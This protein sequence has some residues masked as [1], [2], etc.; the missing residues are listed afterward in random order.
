M[1]KFGR[2]MLVLVLAMG[3]CLGGIVWPTHGVSTVGQPV[4]VNPDLVGTFTDGEGRQIDELRI[5]GRPPVGW[6]APAV[7]LPSD[8]TE[9]DGTTRILTGVPAFDWSYGCSATSA[10]MLFGYYDRLGYPDMYVGPT[11]GGVCPLSNS[12]WGSGETPISASHKDIDGRA[13]KGSVDDYWVKYGST[14][15]DPY[16]TGSWTQHAPLDCTAD[17]MGTNQ[18]KYGN[19]DGSTS[20]YF[21]DDG[22]PLVD[23]MAPAGTMD[24]C[25]GMRMYAQYR[26]YNTATNFSQYIAEGPMGEADGFSFALFTYEIDAGRPVLI[27]CVGHT[28]LAFGYSTTDKTIYIHDTWDHLDHSMTW[29][30]SYSGLQQYGVTVIRLT[31]SAITHTITTSVS[32]GHGTLVPSGEIVPE[33]STAYVR[34]MPAVGYHLSALTDNG[35]VVSPLPAGTNY[36]IWQVDADHTITGAFAIDTHA[37]TVSNAGSGTVTLDPAGGTYA[38][39]TVVAL[40]AAPAAGWHFTGW[41]GDLTGTTNPAT[42]TMDADKTITA[43]FAINTYILSTGQV[44]NGVVSKDPSQATYNHGTFVSLTATPAPGWTFTSW[45]GG[46]PAGHESDNPL[47]LTMDADKTVTATFVESP[48]SSLVTHYYSSILGRSRMNRA[49]CTG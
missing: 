40:T 29:G 11:N 6:V 43:I 48:I 18:S 30:G 24:G 19:S 44:G 5:G 17:Y 38:Y 37:L 27:H 46:V 21:Y 28:M 7:V 15:A 16:I 32:G 9:A 34:I 3:F 22:R 14:A 33:G 36:P 47:S 35:T 49:V 31:L 20:F 26:G 42:V 45:S 25:H 10:A 1:T 23:Y 2:R 4:A 8:S 13:T 12:A 41:S 39:G